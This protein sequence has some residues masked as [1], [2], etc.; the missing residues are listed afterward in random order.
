M[1]LERK[2]HGQQAWDSCESLHSVDQ[3]PQPWRALAQLTPGRRPKWSRLA[4]QS[5]CGLTKFKS[6]AVLIRQV[7][8]VATDK[9]LR[10]FDLQRLSVEGVARELPVLWA[11]KKTVGLARV[12]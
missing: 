5:R 12:D 6:G 8:H 9:K 2:C 4:A 7:G 11:A 3:P 10:L 1:A